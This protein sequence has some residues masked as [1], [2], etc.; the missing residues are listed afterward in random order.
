[1]LSDMAKHAADR[2]VFIKTKPSKKIF[3]HLLDGT[4]VKKIRMGHGIAR[5]VPQ[6]VFEGLRNAG[7]EV[8][9]VRLKAG[10]PERYGKETREKLLAAV[11]KG[12]PLEAALEKYGVSRRSYFYWKK[13]NKPARKRNS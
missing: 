7:V 10:R 11:S 13:K 6:S 8:E 12:M 5:T 2:E 9:I 3:L 4:A 1:M